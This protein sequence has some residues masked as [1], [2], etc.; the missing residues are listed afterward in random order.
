MD[1]V[2][3]KQ[4]TDDPSTNLPAR[5]GSGQADKKYPKAIVGAFIFNDK[6]ELFLMKTKQWKDKYTCPGGKLEIGETLI[7]AVIRETKEETNL[8]IV[9]VQFMGYIDALGLEGKYLIGD[10]HLLFL[11]FVAHA[12]GKQKIKLNDEGTEYKWLKP[13][14]W[15]K[16]KEAAFPHEYVYNRIKQ[17]SIGIPSEYESKYKRAL[18]D[19][20]NLLK[21]TAQEKQD[22][23]KYANEQLVL[24]FIPVYDNLKIS[25]EHIDEAARSNGWAE[26]IKYVIKQFK[27]A[28]TNLGVEEIKA[29]H[30]KFDHSTMEA[31]EGQ[32]DKVV[33]VVRPGYTLNGKVII[34]A[35]VVLK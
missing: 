1:F 19:Y 34:P 2:N 23:A 31:V 13:A 30:K 15:I 16:M 4:M 20:Q 28:L 7:E 6:G 12:K 21:R 11:D 8:D 3:S 27:D 24:E 29:K 26:G 22:F 14:D 9:D 35:R 25:L 5:A 10:K 18:A 32:G 17:L 33:K